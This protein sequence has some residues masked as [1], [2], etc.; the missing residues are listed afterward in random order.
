MRVPG[1]SG[2]LQRGGNGCHGVAMKDDIAYPV[3][4]ELNQ[5]QPSTGDAVADAATK[6][7]RIVSAM[8][9]R[10]VQ[11]GHGLERE[12]VRSSEK[13]LEESL[14]RGLRQKREDAP[15]V[16]VQ[17]H[18]SGIERVKFRGEQAVHVMIKGEIAD[19]QNER[20]AGSVATR[21]R[22]AER[23]G[24]DSVDS[25]RAAVR[26]HSDV[27]CVAGAERI[28]IPNRHAAADE[29]RCSVG[30]ARDDIRESAALERL[31]ERAIV[32]VDGV[33]R[34]PVHLDPLVE[35]ARAPGSLRGVVR[36][37]LE[38]V[39]TRGA[40]LRMNHLAREQRRIRPTPL[41]DH[42]QRDRRMLPE[43][44]KEG[45]GGGRAADSQNEIGGECSCRR[46]VPK[47]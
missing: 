44:L 32:T 12:T 15:A 46:C 11:C 37:K 18:D 16:V 8:V 29:E 4:S 5:V 10:A 1:R 23:S 30:Q 24:Y 34:A 35:P 28:E 19:D 45:P 17:D 9:R 7:R 33:G 27:A 22:S 2:V 42:S 14:I 6:R 43:K 26:H 36:K 40:R 20:A 13:L 3:R 39:L 21:C 38:E 25:V 31:V 41:G 47:E